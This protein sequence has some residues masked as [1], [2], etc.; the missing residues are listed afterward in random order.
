MSI[1]FKAGPVAVDLGADGDLAKFLTPGLNTVLHL[2]DVLKDIQGTPDAK[3][4]DVP[5][6]GASSSFASDTEGSWDL[7]AA[8]NVKLSFR[9][10]LSGIIR[11]TKSGPIATYL[12]GNRKTFNIDVPPNQVCVSIGF[13]VTLEA[14]SEVGYSAGNFGVSGRLTKD[15]VFLV[16]N[17]RC[18]PE[19]TGVFDALGQAFR[20]FK[21]PFLPASA[22]ALQENE[23]LEFEFF[24]RLSLGM[25]ATY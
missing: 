24:G 11:F 25:G 1:G 3:L 7:G 2:G 22:A 14:G 23:I 19:T 21:L 13:R 18:F 12:D 17:H 16:L 4:S 8:V 5:E 6:G 9:P 20:E 10:A 15:D